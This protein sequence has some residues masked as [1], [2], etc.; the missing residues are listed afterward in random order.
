VIKS[1][2]MRLR[3]A[4]LGAQALLNW[5]SAAEQRHIGSKRI[6]PGNSAGAVAGISN[7]ILTRRIREVEADIYQQF[8]GICNRQLIS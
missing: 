8:H 2:V 3:F 1:E 7:L 4:E 6:S 5:I